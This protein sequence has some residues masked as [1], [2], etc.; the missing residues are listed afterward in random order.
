MSSNL[1]VKP[2]EGVT[3]AS[4][5]GQIWNW[6]MTAPSVN[7]RGRLVGY[8]GRFRAMQ[9]APK[10]FEDVCGLAI[11]STSHWVSGPGVKDTIDYITGAPAAIATRPSSQRVADCSATA[12]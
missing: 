10:P 5:P 9:V 12:R 2:A 3:F 7:I 8:C 4:G 11:I 1:N 6:I